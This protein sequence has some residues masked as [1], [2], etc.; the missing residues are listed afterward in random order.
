MKKTIGIIGMGR[1]G[2]SLTESFAKNN[3]DVLALDY[4][5]DR[6]ERASLF[7]DYTIVCDSTNEDALKES[8]IKDCDHVIV[9]F[10]QEEDMNI[11]T[12]IVTVIR[13]KALGINK[14][15]VRVDDESFVD[16][17]HLIGADD[18]IFPLKIASEKIANRITSDS[19]IDY[20]K[21][22]DSFDAYEIEL[23]KEFRE[24]PIVEL[25]ARSKY[26]INILVIIRNG[27]KLVPNKESVLKPKD[28]LIIFGRKKDINKIINFFDTFIWQRW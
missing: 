16:T 6:I 17:M 26:Y 11:A 24:I 22:T 23:K 5:K 18:I 21:M 7:T 1:F 9:A 12:T 10:G 25:N 28:H 3:V 4:R 19:V 13:L 8:G 20:F 14:I 27:E 15:T 2:I